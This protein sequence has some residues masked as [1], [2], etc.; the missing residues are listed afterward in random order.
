MAA[1]QI[2]KRVDATQRR[3][4][5][6]GGARVLEVDARGAEGRADL[7]HRQLLVRAHGG[8]AERTAGGGRQ[9]QL[10]GG[11]E[12][13]QGLA[14]AAEPRERPLARQVFEKRAQHGLEQL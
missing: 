4:G 12:G 13:A 9:A 11:D 10:R 8:D 5:P 2:R 14:A 3:A 1:E 6:E 7:Q